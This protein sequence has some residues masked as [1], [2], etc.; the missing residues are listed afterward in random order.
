MN[1]ELPTPEIVRRYVDDFFHRSVPVLTLHWPAQ[2]H[3]L[4]E[5]PE[6][7][8][9]VGPPPQCFGFHIQ[10]SGRDAYWLRV[11]W[12][13]TCLSWAELSRVQLLSCS[14]APL[15]SA[16]GTDMWSLLEEPVRGESK[17]V[18]RAA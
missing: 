15:L 8:N 11:L 18:S 3:K 5:L 1:K 4:W 16:L 17:A 10:R 13:H 6:G 14:L 7:V 12:N 9:I 2:V